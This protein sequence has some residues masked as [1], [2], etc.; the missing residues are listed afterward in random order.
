[1]TND[2]PLTERAN[3]R[4]TDLD[5]LETAPL[6]ELLVSEQRGAVEAVLAQTAVLAAVVDRIAERIAR[7][8]S[9]HYVGAGSSGRLGVLD[10]S[11]MGPTFGT[12]PHCVCAHIAGGNAALRHALEGAEDDGE[13]GDA[14]IAGHVTAADAVVGISAG[15]RAEYVVRAV[16]RAKQLGAFTVA[17]VNVEHS[18]LALAADAAITLLTSPE[19][20]T[21]STRLAAGTAQKIAL[22]ALSTAVMVKLGK[23]YGN[24][25][26][27]VVANSRKLRARALRLVCTL[28]GAEEARASELLERANGRVK[29]AVVMHRRGVDAVEASELLARHRGSLR[30]VLE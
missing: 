12:E 27:D 26:V 9:L 28:T 14:A 25:M 18:P 16:K 4:S 20:L 22:N 11:E 5:R 1:M 29:V 17:M 10:A 2:L 19:V 8:G 7:G 13:A 15:G 21:G 3:P 30:D 6:V 23:V 24:L